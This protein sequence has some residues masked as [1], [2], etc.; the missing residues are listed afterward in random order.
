MAMI[1]AA[2]TQ[3]NA[4]HAPP[5]TIQRMFSN[6]ET[7]GMPKLSRDSEIESVA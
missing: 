7:A 1:T 4:I 5:M 3:P 6:I 2:I